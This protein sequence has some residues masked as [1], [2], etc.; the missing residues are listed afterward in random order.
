L[1]FGLT[2]NYFVSFGQLAGFTIGFARA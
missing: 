1:A 2:G